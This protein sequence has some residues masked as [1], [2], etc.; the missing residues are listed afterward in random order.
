MA[1]CDACRA[2]SC[3]PVWSLR[4]SLFACHEQ[5]CAAALQLNVLSP[6]LRA[7]RGTFYSAIPRVCLPST[8]PAPHIAPM[9]RPGGME[10][11]GWRILYSAKNVLLLRVAATAVCAWTHELTY[12]PY[13][14][15]PT[16]VYFVQLVGATAGDSP[17]R[18]DAHTPPRTSSATLSFYIDAFWIGS[19]R[20]HPT[21]TRYPPCP[22]P[23]P[24]PLLPQP[25]LWP[26]NTTTLGHLLPWRV[27][28]MQ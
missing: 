5:W 12:R 26:F 20:S 2:H 24:A 19:F 23:T 3:A 14:V 25:G 9:P 21:P 11:G 22:P 27:G 6:S 4:V 15:P 16:T 1:A 18:S 8:L 28:G 13:H 17:R 7:G 10:V